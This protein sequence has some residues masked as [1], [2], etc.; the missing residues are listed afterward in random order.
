MDV[1]CNAS[2]ERRCDEVAR[3]LIN[4]TDL[5]GADDRHRRLGQ[6]ERWY[7]GPRWLCLRHLLS[8]LDDI[9]A[10]EAALRQPLTALPPDVANEVREFVRRRREGRD[11][12]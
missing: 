4:V 10:S 5:A 11:G 6:P 7:T 1:A 12:G 2:G 3:Y 8:Y 9:L